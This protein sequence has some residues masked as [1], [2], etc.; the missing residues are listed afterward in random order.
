MILDSSEFTATPVRSQAAAYSRL[1]YDRSGGVATAVSA[2]SY[3]LCEENAVYAIANHLVLSEEHST[4]VKGL[5]PTTAEALDMQ[6][7][8][9]FG[10]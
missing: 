3:W 10:T 8:P 7:S 5:D 9:N 1:E 4:Q 2:S 6:E